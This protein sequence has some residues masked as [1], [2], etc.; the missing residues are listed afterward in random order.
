[1]GLSTDNLLG[2]SDRRGR[3]DSPG[4]QAVTRDAGNVH[5]GTRCGTLENVAD[6][7]F[8]NTV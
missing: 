1:M 4:T 5:A 7:R 3:R 8:D 6:R 2:D